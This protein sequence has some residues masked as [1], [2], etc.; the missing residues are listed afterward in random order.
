[1]VAIG[2][3]K[4][5]PVVARLTS[6]DPLPADRLYGFKW[7]AHGPVVSPLHQPDGGSEPGWSVAAALFLWCA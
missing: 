3:W 1:M 6:A 5:R 2:E 4:E 7:R